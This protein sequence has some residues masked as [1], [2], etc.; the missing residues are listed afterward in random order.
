MTTLLAADNHLFALARRGQRLTHVAWA[1]VLSLIVPFAAIII[2]GILG[3]G[4]LFVVLPNTTL[5]ES[6]ATGAALT[7]AVFLIFSFVPIYLLVWVWIRWFEKR[8]F[9]TLGFERQ[10]AAKRY[11]I[12]L[13]AGALLFST[14]VAIM[15]AFGYVAPEAGDPR[16]QGTAAL[17]GVALVALGWMV[18]GAAEEVLCRGWLLQTIG[19]R[20]RPSLGVLLSSLVFAV[21]HSLNP[22]LSLIAVLNLF[23]F[24][25]FAALY[26]LYEGGLWGV[27]AVHA[28][29]NWVQ[30]NIFGLAVSGGTPSGGTL[31]DLIEIGPDLITG[32]A[33]GPEGGL[34]VT[35]VLLIGVLVIALLARRH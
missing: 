12:G 9:W 5:I 6:S 22:N 18:Q 30:G 34:A 23:L 8:P 26:A 4:V 10:G 14:A 20:Y 3:S 13:L 7:T 15:A 11:G 21:L 27:C 2:G 17:G 16:F 32:G 35:A 1:L 28:V 33:F 31:F 29:W 19:A 25:L 24:G